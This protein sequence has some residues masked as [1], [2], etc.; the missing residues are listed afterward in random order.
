MYL[1][2]SYQTTVDP[3]EDLKNQLIRGDIKDTAILAEI[4]L[5]INKGLPEWEARFYVAMQ[6]GLVPAGTC[7]CI[8]QH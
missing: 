4:G 2:T 8:F 6:R 3:K 5:L 1:K 7:P